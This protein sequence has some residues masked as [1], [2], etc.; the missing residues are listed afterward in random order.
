MSSPYTGRYTYCNPF[1]WATEI[2]LRPARAGK[3][4]VQTCSP[5]KSR[6]G[7][8]YGAVPGARRLAS[9]TEHTFECTPCVSGVN[10]TQSPL[11]QPPYFICVYS[12]CSYDTYSPDVRLWIWSVA[13]ARTHAGHVRAR[14]AVGT[15]ARNDPCP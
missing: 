12:P 8:A 6:F 5:M 13:H 9:C 7:P 14:I 3:R 15:L 11:I 4:S 10:K 1:A 2:C